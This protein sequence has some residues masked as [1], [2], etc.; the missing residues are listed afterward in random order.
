MDEPTIGLHF[1]EVELLLALLKDLVN[2][3]S[4][5]LLIEH[6]LDL[7]RQSDYLIDMGPEAGPKGGQIIA[8]GSPIQLARN[9]VGFTSSL[10]RKEKRNS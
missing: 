9:P 7:I 10:L 4:S 1:Q 2:K 8:Q 3:G 6:N 5:V